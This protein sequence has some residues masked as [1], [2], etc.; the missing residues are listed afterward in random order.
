MQ[1]ARGRFERR[2]LPLDREHRRTPEALVRAL[3]ALALPLEGEAWC[4][5]QPVRGP[6][7]ALRVA[8]EC[9]PNAARECAA[10][11]VELA[12]QLRKLGNDELAG[13]RGRRG[14]Y[15]GGEIA[16]IGRAH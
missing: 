5:A 13:H 14:A 1:S 10:R 2:P 8:L 6:L 4:G 11:A 3:D 12:R 15:V 9:P 7:Q 16:E